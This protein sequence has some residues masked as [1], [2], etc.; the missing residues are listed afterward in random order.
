[1]ASGP[2]VCKVESSA[3]PLEPVGA[4]LPFNVQPRLQAR[5]NACTGSNAFLGCIQPQLQPIRSDT[6]IVLPLSNTH[7]SPSSITPRAQLVHT[8]KFHEV[9]R[10]LLELCHLV[11]C[12]HISQAFQSQSSDLSG[13][14]PAGILRISS[15]TCSGIRQ[16][17]IG[18]N[19]GS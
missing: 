11:A 15:S 2:S 6:S 9:D 3:K 5:T 4:I 1:M 12:A 18:D 8:C 10:P 13:G 17:G 19:V 16:G 14:V 7:K